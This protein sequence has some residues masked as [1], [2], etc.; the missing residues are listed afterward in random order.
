MEF[1]VILILIIFNGIFSMAEIAIISSRKSKLKQMI[2]EGN[3]NAEAA[4]LLSEQPSY[5]FSTVQIGITAI[6]IITG[7]IGNGQ[8]VAK[9]SLLLQPLP[10]IGVFHYEIALLSVIVVI[11]YLILIIGELVPKRI[12][13]NNPEKIASLLAPLMSTLMQIS[14]PLVKLLSKSTEIVFKLLHIGPRNEPPITEDEIRALIRQGTDMGIFNRTEKQLV[15]R[16]LQLDDLKV[17]ALMI[18]RNKIKFFDMTNISHNPRKYLKNYRYSRVIFARGVIDKIEGIVQIKDLLQSYLDDNDFDIKK[19]LTKP[20]V[21][22]EHTRALK[23]LEL[24]RHSPTHIA[25]VL[26][27]FGNVQGLITLND[28]FESLVGDIK[29]QSSYDDTSV[30]KNNDGSLYLNG[31]LPIGEVKKLLSIDILPK[32]GTGLYHTLGGFVITYL[33]KIPRKGTKFSWKHFDFKIIDMD[34]NRV[35]KVLVKENK[36][37]NSSK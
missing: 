31:M 16:A 7:A 35:D 36:I 14:L 26:D 20:L 29:T 25:I 10:F 27:E 9:L 18:P 12:A 4:Y 22:P 6:G 13:V 33:D 3:K 17:S 8:V 11:T 19:I 34:D 2:K 30:V 5:F 1:I 28:I 32:E 24:F 21:V 37:E 15:E 23:L